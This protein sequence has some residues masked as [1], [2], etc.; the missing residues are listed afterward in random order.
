MGESAG[1]VDRSQ[2][3]VCYI[4]VIGICCKLRTL[5]ATRNRTRDLSGISLSFRSLPDISDPGPLVFILAIVCLR[6]A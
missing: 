1:P 3:A 5:S 2:S 4:S 6:I